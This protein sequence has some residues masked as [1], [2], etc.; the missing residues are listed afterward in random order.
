MRTSIPVLRRVWR[1]LSFCA[2]LAALPSTPAQDFELEAQIGLSSVVLGLAI[3]PAQNR[4]W[5]VS[6]SGSG[7]VSI[8]R[9]SF[10]VTSFT[11]WPGHMYYCDVDPSSGRVFVTEQGSD[12]L[13]A[14]ESATGQLVGSVT[15]GADPVK[16]AVDL[17]SG[18][19]FVPN[20]TSASLSVVD[21]S[22]LQVVAML[23]TGARPVEA[24]VDPLAR[25]VYVALQDSGGV[26]VFDADTYQW[27]TRLLTGAQPQHLAIDPQGHRL[28]VAAYSS[29]MGKISVVD[30]DPLS[31]SFYTVIQSRFQPTYAGS[32]A[33]DA[34]RNRLLMTHPETDTVDVWDL[35]GDFISQSIFVGDGP[36]VVRFDSERRRAFVTVQYGL[37]VAVLREVV[38][39]PPT[40]DAG[41]D[42]EVSC[43]SLTGA[44]I[45]LDGTGSFDPDGDP[46][47][48][49]WTGP[50]GTVTG[51]LPEVS[52]PFGTSTIV[53]TVSD[54]EFE[55]TDSVEI[56]VTVGLEGFLPPMAALVPEADPSTPEPA[57]A[58]KRG[59]TIPLKLRLW[60]GAT[61]LTDAH[62]D[63]PAIVGIWRNGD[64]VNLNV[65]DPDPGESNDNGFLF[66]FSEDKWIFNLST[67]WAQVGRYTIAVRM[68]D[69]K[70]YKSGFQLR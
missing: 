10:L 32:L 29:G 62:V 25:R 15:V 33:F 53:L 67:S 31:G 30:T 46:L 50:F 57:H 18:S 14:F 63:P 27:I 66:R 20:H 69:G 41:P 17:V 68:P 52:L 45:T 28:F 5:V 6:E 49:S 51:P 16:P 3:D 38:N 35:T 56:T 23:P 47:T 1:S 19:V 42:F 44:S 36:Q 11:P 70:V 26:D 9:E 2:V 58:F 12:L 54:G 8:D 13:V 24:V 22:T 4:V 40:A 7:I 60:C 43:N 64:A 21:G 65:I 55:S 39:E 34:L 61:L 37:S 48:Y 59:R